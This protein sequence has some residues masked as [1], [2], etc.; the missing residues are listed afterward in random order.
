VVPSGPVLPLGPEVST[1]RTEELCSMEKEGVDGLDDR[2]LERY[3]HEEEEEH[4]HDH[5]AYVYCGTCTPLVDADVVIDDDDD[6]VDGVTGHDDADDADDAA[7][8]QRR[9]FHR[10][11]RPAAAG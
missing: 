10:K 2:T 1:R 8:R 11:A 7:C 5:T 6:G 9:I 4:L 3:L